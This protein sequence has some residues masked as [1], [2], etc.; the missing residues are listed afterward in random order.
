MTS[1]S[2]R[3]LWIGLAVGLIGLAA[4]GAGAGPADRDLSG[5]YHTVGVDPGGPRYFGVTELTGTGGGAYTIV[6]EIGRSRIEG[7]GSFDGTALQADF[8]SISAS[9][10]YQLR[11]EGTLVGS[12]GGYGEP[13]AGS[14]TLAP[15][16]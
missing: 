10:V 6:Q 16:P 2:F 3:L 13:Q 4:P 15:L 8:P 5:R 1:F 11:P 14:E 12:W 9:A 7:T